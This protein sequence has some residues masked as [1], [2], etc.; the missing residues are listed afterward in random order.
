MSKKPKIV[1]VPAD[2]LEVIL[3][4][5]EAH[6][7]GADD[8]ELIRTLL[9]SYVELTE[10][11]KNK[12]TSLTRLRNLLFGASTEKAAALLGKTAA[13]L[14]EATSPAGAEATADAESSTPA[15]NHGR[16][17]VD[18]YTGAKK[19]EVPHPSL[20]PGDPCPQCDNGT[21]Y[22]T[23]RPGVLVRVTGQPPLQA[24]AYFLQ[25]LRCNLCGTLFTADAPDGVGSEKYDATARSML[26]LLKYGAGMPF[27]RDEKLHAN[28]G[29]PL[30]ASTQWDIVETHAQHVEPAF[31]EMVRQGAQGEVLY[32]D[33]TG[34]KILQFKRA[35]AAEANE[36]SSDNDA[37]ADGAAEQPAA[38]RRG[39]FT[40]GIVATRDGQKIALFFSGRQHAGE[41]LKDVLKRRAADLPR[42]IQMC[43]AL[44]RNL[45]GELQTILANCLAHGRRQF[46]EIFDRFPD[47]CRHVIETLKG[48]YAND[49]IA[50]QQKL[51]AEQ[52]LLFHQAHSGPTMKELHVWLEAQFAQRLVEPN[53]ALGVAISY[54]LKRWD[55]L[56][57]FLRQAGA[58]LDNNICE[59]ALKV[60]IRHRKNSLFYKTCHGAHVGDIFMSLIHTCELGGVNPFDYLTELER[61]AA[62]LALSPQDWMPWNYRESVGSPAQ[63]QAVA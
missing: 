23:G 44:S 21:V 13:P 40:T 17:G 61:H 43:D 24:M 3:Q 32:N 20:Q 30:P 54:L 22:E 8:W 37:D 25:K 14:S 11:L 56:T 36:E 27:H 28:L 63:V 50:R 58:P 10:L 29:I 62:D 51:S 34:V 41:N 39:M 16:N 7:L 1:E 9:L 35:E 33:D 26:A 5:V 55:K 53:S 47:H 31:E 42:P 6:E 18:A 48:V 38:E 45:P 52:R 60:A 57:L 12:N 46:V 49:A 19:I 2:S 59:R 4:H 15:K